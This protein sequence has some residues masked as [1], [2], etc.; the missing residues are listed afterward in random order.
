MPIY[1]KADP[2]KGDVTS[3]GFT[4]QIELQSFQWGA[5]LGVDSARGANRTASEPSVSE[6]VVSKQT[7]KASDGL[8]KQLL[9][10][11]T[12]AKVVVSFTRSSEAK[13]ETYLAI[14]LSDV[15]ISGW[16]QSSGGDRPTESV[17]LNFA[18]FT[19][20]STGQ[21]NA[22][23]AASPNRLTYDLAQNKVS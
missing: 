17:S 3:E 12:L 10:G 14:E 11:K 7:D 22:G 21:S 4:D 15:F 19:F 2:I 18:K 5:G 6:I 16:T 1:M 20:S 23:K 13:I 8:F 9:S